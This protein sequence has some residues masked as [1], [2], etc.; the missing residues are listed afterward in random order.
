MVQ[1]L[2]LCPSQGFVTSIDAVIRAQAADD[3]SR[4]LMV[5]VRKQALKAVL[6]P[7]VLSWTLPDLAPPAWT[8]QRNFCSIDGQKRHNDTLRCHAG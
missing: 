6:L 1:G 8:Q 7:T 4:R 2:L 5:V 3:T